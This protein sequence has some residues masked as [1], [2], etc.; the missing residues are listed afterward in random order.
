M[1][2]LGHFIEGFGS[3]FDNVNRQTLDSIASYIH[4]LLSEARRKNIERIAE[5]KPTSNYQN[6]QYA[7]SEAQW[8]H[9]QIIDGVAQQANRFFQGDKDSSLIIDEFGIGKKGEMSVGVQRQWNGRLGKTDNCQVA[10][11]GVLSSR[12]SA[13]PIDI[14]LFLPESWVD[15]PK[16]CSK[17]GIPEEEQ[18]ARTKLELATEIIANAVAQD[19]DFKWVGFDAFYGRSKKFLADLDDK[20]LTF[21]GDV[22][23]TH[24]VSLPNRDQLQSVKSLAE[25]RKFKRVVLR[26]QAK[27]YLQVDA[28]SITVDVT[29]KKGDVRKWRLIVTK[30]I[31]SEDIKYSFTNSKA[32]LRRVAY[33]QR[34]RF[35]VERTI[36]DAKTSCG[37]AQYQVRGWV[38]WHH[39]MALVM[40]AMLFLF[41]ERL[42][43][44]ESIPLLSC[45]D[46]VGVLA[47]G[48]IRSQQTIESEID[49][50]RERHRQRF[51]DIERRQKIF[52]RE[53]GPPKSL[54]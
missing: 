9:R 54:F 42:L 17:A 3:R 33:M 7:V 27:G 53:H 51:R 25:K 16:R 1:D 12:A 52:I 44:G 20:N 13:C 24:Q 48:L 47:Q 40:L 39:H 32:S 23:V 28:M 21:V 2:R 8:D 30:E 14:R 11:L 43:H 29:V 34:Q 19:L 15:D 50:V 5:Q 22:P 45:Q 37:M 10:V 4:G 38:P 26:P 36:Q 35:W 18:I 49:A 41:Q 6:I 31:G 46:I